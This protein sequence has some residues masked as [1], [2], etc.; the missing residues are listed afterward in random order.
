[1]G[2]ST[3]HITHRPPPPGTTLGAHLH[4]LRLSHDPFCPWCRTTPEAMEHFLLQCPCFHSQH[5][6]LRSLLSTL[7]I[8]TLDLSTLLAASGVHPSWQPTVLR[9]T[10]AFLRKTS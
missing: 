9:L 5:T 7:A 10:Y 1:M 4:R 6:A 8:T 3:R 2:S